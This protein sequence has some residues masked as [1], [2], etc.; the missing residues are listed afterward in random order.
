[1]RKCSCLKNQNKTEQK[2]H[3]N[4]PCLLELVLLFK[5]FMQVLRSAKKNPEKLHFTGITESFHLRTIGMPV[6]ARWTPDLQAGGS[7]IF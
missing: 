7:E 4:K 2:N 1:M 6:C 5:A 3:T